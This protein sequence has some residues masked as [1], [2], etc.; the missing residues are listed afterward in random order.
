MIRSPAAPDICYSLA[1]AGRTVVRS[2]LRL[3]R[4]GADA[5]DSAAGW[6]ICTFSEVPGDDGP[7]RLSRSMHRMSAAGWLDGFR[8]EQARRMVIVDRRKEAYV[9]SD[10]QYVISEVQTI[11]AR[12]FLESNN[13][14]SISGLLAVLA[15]LG[16]TPESLP[17]LP[18]GSYEVVPMPIAFE[19]GGGVHFCGMI[20]ETGPDG[21][22]RSGRIEGQD[23]IVTAE[24]LPVPDALLA[25][26]FTRQR[27]LT[28]AYP[29]QYQEVS[30]EAG[31]GRVF[32]TLATRPG[33]AARPEMAMLIGGTGR[34]NRDGQTLS[35]LNIGYGRFMDGL[36]HHGLASLRFDRRPSLG[37]REVLTQAD[38]AAQALSVLDHIAR[39]LQRR[40]IVIGHS[41]GGLVAAEIA[42]RRDDVA[43][44]VLISTPATTLTES[45][46]WQRARAIDKITDP[47]MRAQYAASASAFDE[48]LANAD[49]ESLGHVER[50]SIAFIRSMAGRTVFDVLGEVT[51]PVLLLQGALDEQVPQ[52]DAATIASWLQARGKTV[53][54]LILPH[55]GHFL[56]PPESR[57]DETGAARTLDRDLV[58]AI[59]DHLP[60]LQ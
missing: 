22:I 29:V 58:R 49:L 24:E 42:Q 40:A 11:P 28:D 10:G 39:H 51:A 12:H 31:F 8:F 2:W 21:L 33:P 20:L 26:L 23:V 45:I 15:K 34:Y 17:V 54:S 9:F 27:D 57:Q 44:L 50:S 48:K 14:A 52:E 36:A 43:L 18:E 30:V 37:S 32:G 53:N 35:G 6:E 41:Y 38:I 5:D 56:T 13:F 25:P 46:S 1:I 19:P 3:V 4:L 16:Q 59:L 60:P 47:G 55:M 7:P